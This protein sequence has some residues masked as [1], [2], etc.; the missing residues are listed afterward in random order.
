MPK[1]KLLKTINNTGM[2]REGDGVVVAFSG[3]GDSTALLHALAS[4]RSELKIKLFACHLNH[5][6][7]G[8]EADEDAE[9]CRG[10]ADKLGIPIYIKEMNIAGIAAKRG[11][12]IE[13]AGRNA[14]TAFYRRSM[15]HF[16]ADK[17]ATAHHM[18]D[19]AETFLI[20]L[21][22][23]SGETGLGGIA[24]IRD[25]WL[26]RPLIKCPKSEIEK[27]L[28]ENDIPF[29]TDKT[30]ADTTIIR[31]RI[32]L[33]LIPLLEKDYNPR[34][35]NGLSQTA[36]IIRGA[37]ELSAE[38]ADAFFIKIVSRTGDSVSI[39][40]Q[41]FTVLPIH[42]KRILIRKAFANASG[43]RRRLTFEQVE[44]ILNAVRTSA[45][46]SRISLPFGFEAEISENK[47]TILP[48]KKND[49]EKGFEFS[50]EIPGEIEIPDIGRSW[51]I[52]IKIYSAPLLE[53]S[54]LNPLIGIFDVDRFSS[55]VS[56]RNRRDGDR[57]QPLGMQG[58]K[59]LQDIFMDKKIPKRRREEL[60][61]FTSG[62]EIFWIP[63]IA[64]GERFKVT[65]KTK[66]VAVFAPIR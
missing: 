17:T 37:D 22:R 6:L 41:L 32:R 33:T 49:T 7:R 53:E 12:N 46:D 3:G 34:I 55:P 1:E 66:K 11:W 18:N 65:D 40:K 45:K 47:I 51:R 62:G 56:V 42:L 27:Y 8:A 2:L 30:N 4:M 5:K 10:F 61:V 29:R 39:E 9:F 48:A 57:M 23:G 44:D 43:S 63:G 54:L 36:D 38:L 21:L 28:M 20:N 14:R 13:E 60:P 64:S 35:V 52:E 50:F 19:Q 58:T 59:K 25:G 24:P 16:G 15:R 31:N 26:I